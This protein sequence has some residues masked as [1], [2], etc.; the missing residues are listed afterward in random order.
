MFTTLQSSIM[1]TRLPAHLQSKAV[2][3]VMITSQI[4]RSL[5]PIL[6]TYTYAGAKEALPGPGT[7]ANAARLYMVLVGGIG[8]WIPTLFYFRAFFGKMTDPSPA[9]LKKLDDEKAG[10]MY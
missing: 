7:G 3:A 6:S 5:G 9:A 10:A 8:M 1:T 2:A 4:G